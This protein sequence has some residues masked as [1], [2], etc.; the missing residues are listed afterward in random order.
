M[1]PLREAPH[2]PLFDGQV[3]GG[4]EVVREADADRL[5]VCQLAELGLAVLERAHADVGH[6]AHLVRR[7]SP[8]RVVAGGPVDVAHQRLEVDVLGTV[9]GHPAGEVDVVAV[10]G[11]L[12]AD[13]RALL[14]APRRRDDRVRDRVGELVRVAREDEL[15]GIHSSSHRVSPTFKVQVWRATARRSSSLQPL[16]RNATATRAFA[17]VSWCS[18]RG[19]PTQPSVTSTARRTR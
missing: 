17:R 13:Q 15:S 1:E 10:D 18:L 6:D 9:A 3:A 7:R 19:R 2:E 14:A 16:P 11:D 5:I 4:L 12:D 8:G